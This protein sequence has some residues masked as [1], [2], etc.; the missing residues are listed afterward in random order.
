MKIETIWK[1]CN[2][3]KVPTKNNATER[4]HYQPVLDQLISIILKER[5]PQD[6]KMWSTKTVP[7]RIHLESAYC[8]DISFTKALDLLEWQNCIA[9]IELKKDLA[10]SYNIAVG[11]LISYCNRA[12]RFQSKRHIIGVIT[13]LKF[14]DFWL[15]EGGD[16]AYRTGVIPLLTGQNIASHGF[17]IL[18]SWL[19]SSFS[20]MGYT[21]HEEPTTE[22]TTSSQKY[23]F[24][25]LLG[26][27]NDSR[28]YWARGQDEN[29]YVVKQQKRG[30]I[31]FKTEIKVLNELGD[32]TGVPQ[33]METTKDNDYSYIIYHSLDTEP[34]ISI[35][36][37]QVQYEGFF[38]LQYVFHVGLQV[39]EILEQLEKKG[40]HHGDVRP[41]N[42]VVTNTG[43]V[44][45]LVQLIDFGLSGKNKLDSSFVKGVQ[46]YNSNRCL[47]EFYQS[48][49]CTYSVLDD[50][51]SLI[52]SMANMGLGQ[53]DWASYN[54]ELRIISTRKVFFDNLTSAHIFSILYGK[55]TG[56]KTDDPIP[57]AELKELMNGQKTIEN[58]KM[59]I[60]EV[61]K[62][63][64]C[65]VQIQER[66]LMG[67]KTKTR[68]CGR[69][70]P[71]R[72]H[73]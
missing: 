44:S 8:P 50:V 16:N 47:E 6:M 41:S 7:S 13:D 15:L 49:S 36:Q 14:A 20:S 26:V 45:P 68:V 2:S 9:F 46:M 66:K 56:L 24:L 73:R 69:T 31:Q 5:N 52:Y 27:G 71:C 17:K 4:K 1:K 23:H 11:Q 62:I 54:N 21:K 55:V 39:L 32:M 3:L 38:P 59:E 51:E 12:K 58:E 29:F 67:I 53:L 43:H 61:K 34:R 37:L 72:Y 65:T 64:N 18:V 40:Y 48:H 33:V 63:S 28:V 25:E 70:M 22:V 60:R 57:W 10:K 35:S 19:L 42:I 30:N